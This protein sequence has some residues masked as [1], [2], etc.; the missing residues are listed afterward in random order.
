M[1][2]KVDA[3]DQCYIGMTAWDSAA[4]LPITYTLVVRATRG[5]YLGG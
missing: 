3:T 5:S 1:F 2:N 4:A